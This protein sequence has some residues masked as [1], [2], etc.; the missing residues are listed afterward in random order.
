MPKLLKS[1]FLRVF[2]IF[3]SFITFI[4]LFSFLQ[5]TAQAQST[6]YYVATNGSDSN[7]GT[8]SRP[9]RTIGKATQTLQAGDTVNIRGGTYNERLIPSR[10]GTSGI[11]HSPGN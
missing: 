6:S 7:P 5:K 10:S 11:P 8:L 2:V 1:K 9:W 4:P 3:V